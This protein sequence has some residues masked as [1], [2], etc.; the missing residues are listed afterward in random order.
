MGQIPRREAKEEQCQNP[1][2]QKSLKCGESCSI[3][4]KRWEVIH[5]TENSA[6]GDHPDMESG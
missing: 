3:P 2:C 5:V 4:G 6:G 1:D